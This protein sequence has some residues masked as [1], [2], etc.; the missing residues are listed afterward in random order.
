MPIRLCAPSGNT[1]ICM[2]S[3]RWIDRQRAD[4]KA[5]VEGA[6]ARV[7]AAD[8]LKAELDDEAAAAFKP[9][10][11]TGRLNRALNEFD[12]QRRILKDATVRSYAWESAER[13]Y[14]QA[15]VK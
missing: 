2:S 5:G 6:D 8:Q 14:R 13:D 15:E 4:Q 10:G 3:A 9:R 12:E 1:T 7:A 11:S